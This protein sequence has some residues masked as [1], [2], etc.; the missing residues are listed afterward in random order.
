MEGGSEDGRRQVGWKEAGRSAMEVKQDEA[1]R[2]KK[3]AMKEKRR[4]CLLFNNGTEKSKS[5]YSTMYSVHS[6]QRT[7]SHKNCFPRSRIFLLK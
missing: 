6:W 5:L 4:K 1:G 2:T 7:Q 3:E